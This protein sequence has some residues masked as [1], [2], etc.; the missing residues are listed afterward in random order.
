[1]VRVL[2]I[3]S[4]LLSVVVFSS[5]ACATKEDV[6]PET[7]RQ[8][9][10]PLV[11]TKDATGILANQATLHGEL[12]GLGTA[13]GV[14]VSFQWGTES[15]SYTKE[16][17]IQS[18]TG[19]GAFSFDLTGLNAD[20]SY[21][22]RAKAV[23]D[24]TSYGTGKDFRT[25]QT[26][27]VTTPPLVATKDATGIM[28]NQATLNGDLTGLGTASGVSV[29]FQ[30]GTESGSYTKETTI[31]SKTGTGVFSFDLTGLNADTSYYFRAKAVGVGTSYG[32]EK[33]FRTPQ[34]GTVTTPPSVATKDATGIMAN[35]ATLNGELT[36]L[37]TASGVSVSFQWGTESGS[38]TKE[39]T[40]QSKTGTG[41]FSFDLTGL[42]ADTSYYFRAKAVG[43]GTSYG[44]ERNFK[45]SR[46]PQIDKDL[47]GLWA[48]EWGSDGEWYLFR[49]DGTFRYVI[50]GSGPIISGGLV[51]EGQ[52]NAQGGI[53][54]FADCKESWYPD[55][56]ASGQKPA[57]V[58]KPVDFGPL[59]YSFTGS[60]YCKIGEI[61]GYNNTY[62]RH[63]VSDL[64]PTGP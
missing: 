56:T 20:T 43:Y 29:S 44:T 48:W 24:S 19:T 9:T 8:T 17:T 40:I 33:N 7:T 5:L 37:G 12:T 31:Q 35:Q 30:W 3:L 36:G 18:K 51:V 2:L 38:Y 41:A 62:L 39:T 4:V 13:S 14:S 53:L 42:N 61:A 27:T 28:A 58:N 57:Y 59:Q 1:M 34:T 64:P 55:P 15:G 52:Y 10:P 45:T 25:P 11:S 32:T 22:F 16:T 60:D 49:D 63:P 47:V 6:T 50:T 21:Y 26:G 23:G 54:Q 46:N